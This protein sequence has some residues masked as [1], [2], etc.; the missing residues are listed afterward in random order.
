MH[1]TARLTEQ[2]TLS[3]RTNLSEL[4]DSVNM[5]I[6]MTDMRI[7]S[8][9]KQKLESSYEREWSDVSM[10]QS[11]NLIAG[12]ENNE[13][14]TVSNYQTNEEYEEADEGLFA[15][16][17]TQSSCSRSSVGSEAFLPF[18]YNPSV[19]S[20]SPP[21]EKC[22]P[23]TC[24]DVYTP[25]SL[26][27]I[28]D[29]KRSVSGPKACRISI[30]LPA[31]NARRL[32]KIAQHQPETLKGL[33]LRTLKTADGS[34]I[35][36]C[37]KPLSMNPKQEDIK[38]IPKVQTPDS[39]L[40]HSSLGPEKI[41]L[42]QIKDKTGHREEKPKLRRILTKK[43]T[44]AQEKEKSKMD[45]LLKMTAKEFFARKVK[46]S[47]NNKEIWRDP[48]GKSQQ[49]LLKR[50]QAAE[51]V[52]EN[53]SQEQE[54]TQIDDQHCQ[55][56]ESK[57]VEQKPFQ[58]RITD[59]IDETI[60]SVIAIATKS[61]SSIPVTMPP[62]KQKSSKN[63][64]VNMTDNNATRAFSKRTSSLSQLCQFFNETG[65]GGLLVKPVHNRRKAPKESELT[66]AQV[67][68]LNGADTQLSMGNEA[69]NR[70]TTASNDSKFNCSNTIN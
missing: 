20:T 16:S 33:G 48:H 4:V 55:L 57:V 42:D 43:E 51:Q 22:S 44:L 62:M 60:N 15:F 70:R 29:V 35:R 8:S 36:L 41:K 21:T 38:I 6:D 52:V 17:N 24:A 53:E 63:W 12:F 13:L 7:I 32:K 11:N 61:K 23:F 64:M 56:G 34:L 45:A 5:N 58:E 31:K 67:I 28:S 66:L 37:K 65:K 40:K 49:R 39:L 9:S 50:M 2:T 59:Q 10:F 54:F 25:E 26:F 27:E 1:S 46:N 47:N 18:Y 3:T 19:G 68:R 30:R 14:E 69:R